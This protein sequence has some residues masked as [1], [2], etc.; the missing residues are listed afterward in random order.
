MPCAFCSHTIALWQST[1]DPAARHRYFMPFNEYGDSTSFAGR[2]R[3]WRRR[4]VLSK[5]END[6][7]NNPRLETVVGFCCLRRAADKQREL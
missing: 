7:D 5:V 6:F 2:R 3:S 1:L 4:G